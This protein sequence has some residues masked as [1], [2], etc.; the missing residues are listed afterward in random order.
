MDI[1]T[2]DDLLMRRRCDDMRRGFHSCRQSVVVVS[3]A[4][5][6]VHQ[7]LELSWSLTRFK[8]L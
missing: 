1:R 8:H 5:S 6:A 7:V 2:A 3:A 4:H